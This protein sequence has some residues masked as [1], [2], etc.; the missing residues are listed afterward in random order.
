[1]YKKVTT[2]MNF[3]PRE[4]EIL[5]FWKENEVFEKRIAAG[6]R[7]AAAKKR[8]AV[9]LQNLTWLGACRRILG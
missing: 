5:E 6:I 7:E 3:V 2:D 4:K 8:C 1:M 9:S